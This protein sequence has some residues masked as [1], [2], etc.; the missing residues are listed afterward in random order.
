V[1]SPFWDDETGV[2]RRIN[3]G[4]IRHRFVGRC[5]AILLCFHWIDHIRKS[6]SFSTAYL[7]TCGAVLEI[8]LGRAKPMEDVFE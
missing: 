2:H 6:R 1:K 4:S 3:G 8:M 5:P 7:T